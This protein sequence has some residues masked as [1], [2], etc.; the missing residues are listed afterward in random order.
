MI[1]TGNRFRIRAV[2]KVA[3]NSTATLTASE[4]GKGII[5]STSAAATSLT[6]PLAT[7]VISHLK[8]K[9]GDQYDFVVDNSAGANTVT[10][11]VNTGIAAGPAVITG[12]ATLTIAN[13]SVGF[14]KLY[15]K[16]G[17]EA[18]LYRTS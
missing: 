10:M 14:F 5:T 13:G 1:R 18:I 11:V 6:L 4:L 12:G 15:F 9:R 7:K 3:K 2:K 16:S 8:A 17:T